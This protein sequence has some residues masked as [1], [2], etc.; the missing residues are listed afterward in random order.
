[1]ANDDL[2]EVVRKY[3]TRFS[4]YT[5]IPTQDIKF[6]VAEIERGYRDLGFIGAV[7]PVGAV[8]TLEGAKQVAPV[9]EVL[10]QHTGILYFHSG[11]AHASIKGQR[12]IAAPRSDVAT[13]RARYEKA[14]SYARGI[15]TL[16]QTDFLKPY[17]DVTVI[18]AMLGGLAPYHFATASGRLKGVSG[19]EPISSLRRVYL[20]ASTSRTPHTLE[21]VASLFGAD[22]MLFGTDYGVWPSI[23]PIVSAVRRSQLTEAQQN[24]LFVKNGQDLL[25]AKS[26]RTS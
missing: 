1:V 20:D 2:A 8:Q 13:M 22:R 25:A 6:A 11:A 14:A 10:Q 9:L 24:L 4:G 15:T 12:T 17:P 16:T 5:A 19:G 7:L 18:L 26:R 3:P 21:L 23:A